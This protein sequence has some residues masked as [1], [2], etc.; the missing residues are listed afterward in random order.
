MKPKPNDLFT[1]FLEESEKLQDY[2]MSRAREFSKMDA[3][4][5]VSEV[6]MR[7]LRSTIEPITVHSLPAYV[8]RAIRNQRSRWEKEDV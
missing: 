1:F 4:D 6:M 8:F 5:I 7:M 3:E 2:A